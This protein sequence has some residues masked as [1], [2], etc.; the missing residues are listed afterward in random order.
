MV[1]L[2][3]RNFF[4]KLNN[5]WIFEYLVILVFLAVIAGI[6]AAFFIIMLVIKRWLTN[7]V[8]ESGMSD[9]KNALKDAVASEKEAYSQPKS[10]AGL[11][12]ILL[13]KIQNRSK[14]NRTRRCV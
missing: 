14:P 1:S 12:K 9:F 3:N 7:V 8:G 10:V 5:S 2:F 6:V 4:K 11:T 13:P